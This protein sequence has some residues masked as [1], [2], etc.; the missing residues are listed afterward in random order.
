M[1]FELLK[2]AYRVI[3]AIPDNVIDLDQIM[4]SNSCG[5]CC[6]AAGW[7]AQNWA[8]KDLGLGLPELNARCR[9]G[10]ELLIN[11]EDR[12]FDA[13]MAK[14][15]GTDCGT[16]YT[17]FCPRGEENWGE[18][19]LPLTD[20]QLWLRRVRNYLEEHGESLES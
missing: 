17:L 13:A 1:N 18:F 10:A 19:D 11:G 12:R 3:E 9:I 16:A 4:V 14:V 5:T 2:H 20:K 7:L 8:F 15:L 6:C